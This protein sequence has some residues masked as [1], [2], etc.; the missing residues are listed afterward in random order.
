MAQLN[1]TIEVETAFNTY[2]LTEQIG[3]GGAGRVYG[4][5]D[6]EKKPVALKLLTAGSSDKR[7]RFKNEINFLLRNRHANIVTVSDYGLAETNSLRG[8]FYVMNRYAGSARASMGKLTPAAALTLFGQILNGVEAAHLQGAIHRDLKPENILLDTAGLPAIA[9]FGIAAFTDDLLLTLVETAPTTRLANFQYAAPEQRTPGKAICQRADIYA[10]G[11]MLNELFTGE[12]PHG[13]QYRL[14]GSGAGEYE[15]LDEIVATMIRQVATDRPPTIAAVKG[16]IERYRADAITQQKISALEQVVIPA[17]E[18]DDPLAHE[19]PKLTGAEWNE[20]TLSLTLDRPV[21][22]EWIEALHEMGNFT[23][24]VGAH[25]SQFRFQG[26]N[27]TVATADHSAQQVIDYFKH[28]LP[29]T[30][31]KLHHTLTERQQCKEAERRM[32]LQN[33]LSAERRRL[34]V[35]SS[36]RI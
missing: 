23:S 11:L 5:I 16:M 13:T 24:V 12:V 2:H 15:F 3:Q 25:P 6:A 26:R 27:A 8:P 7:R 10:L 36:L 18:I 19:P 9:D 20:G 35:N 28:W 32:Q 31:R 33:E 34:E 30:T 14:I 29:N 21:H 17:G 1:A 4:G 22:R